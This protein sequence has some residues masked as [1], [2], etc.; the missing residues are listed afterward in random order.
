MGEAYDTVEEVVGALFGGI[1]AG[2]FLISLTPDTEE[3][4]VRNAR[5]LLA[6]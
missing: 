4:L 1:E 2:D 6:D 3:K 5:N